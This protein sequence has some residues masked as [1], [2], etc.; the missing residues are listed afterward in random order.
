MLRGRKK[1]DA[2]CEVSADVALGAN[3]TF[4]ELPSYAAVFR[5]LLADLHD[6]LPARLERIRFLAALDEDFGGSSAMMPGG[7][8]TYFAY[9]EARHSYVSGNFVAVVLLS[10]AMIETLLAAHLM[11]D[12]LS[13]DIHGRRVE[14]DAVPARPSLDAVIKQCL[15][16]GVI[17][18]NDETNIRR[19][20]N[21]RNPLTHFRHM[22][23]P[24]HLERRAL[25]ER[26]H[27]LEIL[28]NDARFCITTVI[29]LLSKPEFAIGRRHV[30]S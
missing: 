12:N 10:Q 18:G 4:G 30:E 27:A 26:T 2:G 29:Q 17:N 8:G 11:L 7:H 5:T 1:L 13:R 6:D 19:L 9:A 24:T 15:E 14:G 25:D 16:R 3:V 22:D 20:R 28:A 23:D 21:L